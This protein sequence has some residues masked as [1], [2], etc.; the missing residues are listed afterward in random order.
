[1]YFSRNT[2]ILFVLTDFWKDSILWSSNQGESIWTNYFFE[3]HITDVTI[4]C[5]KSLESLVVIYE[6]DVVNSSITPNNIDLI[7]YVTTEI[8]NSKKNYDYKWSIDFRK[9]RFRSNDILLSG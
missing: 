6:W 4:F 8:S 1:M 9:W 7:M 5:N 2:S 3:S